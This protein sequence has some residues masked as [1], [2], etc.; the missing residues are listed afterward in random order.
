MSLICNS[1]HTQSC[2]SLGK[3]RGG[4]VRSGGLRIERPT[5]L[6]DGSALLG[7]AG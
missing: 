3:K 7:V 1:S 4:A 2:I 6:A 5:Y